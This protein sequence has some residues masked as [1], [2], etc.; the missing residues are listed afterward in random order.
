M[1]L[2]VAADGYRMATALLIASP[3]QRLDATA[4]VAHM[5]F[6]DEFERGWALPGFFDGRVLVRTACHE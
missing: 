5:V 1:A 6:D 2:P 3:V 4:I